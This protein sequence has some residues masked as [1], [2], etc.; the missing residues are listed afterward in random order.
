LGSWLARCQAV[1]LSG[2]WKQLSKR[3]S[4]TGEVCLPFFNLDHDRQT[5]VAIIAQLGMSLGEAKARM[6]LA[7]YWN[8]FLPA[9]QT[10]PEILKSQNLCSGRTAPQNPRFCPACIESDTALLGSAYWH[11]AHQLPNI[12]GCEQHHLQLMERCSVCGHLPRRRSVTLLRPLST[13][14]E[15]GADLRR[16]SSRIDAPALYWRFVRFSTEALTSAPVPLPAKSIP[17]YFHQLAN[18]TNPI[19]F[20]ATVNSARGRLTPRGFDLDLSLSCRRS[21][22][23]LCLFFVSRGLSLAAALNQLSKVAPCADA[24]SKVHSWRNNPSVAE[25]RGALRAWASTHP[26]LGPGSAGE[27]YWRVRLLDERWLNNH[28][29]FRSGR[30]VPSIVDDREVITRYLRVGDRR[31]AAWTTAGLRAGIR[32]AGWLQSALAASLAQMHVQRI[33]KHA[34]EQQRLL[35]QAV[36]FLQSA[37]PPVMVSYP[38][39]AQCTGL[40][41]HVIGRIVRADSEL[42]TLI[43]EVNSTKSYRLLRWIAE[44][45]LSSGEPLLSTVWAA[46]ARLATDTR[47]TQ[48]M[49]L[50]ASELSSLGFDLGARWTLHGNSGT[51]AR[52]HN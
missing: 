9:G 51:L 13:S 7:P 26:H 5:I 34:A 42:S 20:N 10:S 4:S 41:M 33:A 46:R 17:T 24:T 21:T 8:R 52:V 1:A 6:T 38:R 15:C 30:R 19:Q 18:A 28:F 3:Y 45:I 50:I 47:T 36:R 35:I 44:D 29:S 31:N 43:R 27:L 39:L 14:C 11:R 48:L 2:G 32:D 40:P 12:F 22:R 49:Y 16:Q 37:E 23:E 25:C